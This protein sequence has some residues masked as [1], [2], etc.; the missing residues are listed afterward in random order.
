[1]KPL[2]SLAKKSPVESVTRTEAVDVAQADELYHVVV[3]LHDGLAPKADPTAP[4][5]HQH[6]A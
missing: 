6:H 5:P 4:G 2:A 1:M 3:F